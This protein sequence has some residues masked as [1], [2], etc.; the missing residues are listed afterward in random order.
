V[1][2]ALG[3]AQTGLEVRPHRVALAGIE[4]VT[5]ERGT[6]LPACAEWE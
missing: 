1:S 3:V 4:E 6:F 2:D 5:C